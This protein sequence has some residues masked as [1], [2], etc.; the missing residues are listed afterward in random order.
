MPPRTEGREAVFTDCWVPTSVTAAQMGEGTI[1]VGLRVS[2]H[3]KR[4]ENAVITVLSL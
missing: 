3:S 2:G 4:V 1:E